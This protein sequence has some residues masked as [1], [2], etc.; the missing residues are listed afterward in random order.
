MLIRD[1]RLWHAGMPNRT[2]A[3]RPM[4]AMI[5]TCPWLATGTPLVF[6]AGTESFFD[7]PIL[8]AAARFTGDPIDY[9]GAPRGFEYEAEPA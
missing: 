3:P 5:H 1:I 8:T 7:H 4:I 6:P 2:S 9:V